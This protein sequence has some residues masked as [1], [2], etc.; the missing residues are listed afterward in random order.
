[1]T[2]MRS[3]M[4]FRQTHGACKGCKGRSHV[5]KQARTESAPPRAHTN[6]HTHTHAHA[7]AHTRTRTRT[8]TRSRARAH[9]EKEG[10]QSVRNHACDLWIPHLASVMVRCNPHTHTPDSRTHTHTLTHTPSHT[11]T[12]PP[13][14]KPFPTWEP[15]PCA[16]ATCAPRGGEK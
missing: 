4:M 5:S 11:H 13:S 7:H 1:M 12:L 10:Q 14:G 8:R 15:R 6:T 9:T 3:G 2:T 16:W